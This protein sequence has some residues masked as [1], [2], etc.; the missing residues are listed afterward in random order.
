MALIKTPIGYIERI[1]FQKVEDLFYIKCQ[2]LGG[3]GYHRYVWQFGI[4]CFW[5][6]IGNFVGC[7]KLGNWLRTK[8]RREQVPAGQSGQLC[9]GFLLNEGNSSQLFAG[10]LFKRLRGGLMSE[11][12]KTPLGYLEMVGLAKSEQD[13][14]LCVLD[15]GAE[16]RYFKSGV[17]V[18]DDFPPIIKKLEKICLVVGGVLLIPLVYMAYSCFSINSI[19][20][21]PVAK[22]ANFGSAQEE[23]LRSLMGVLDGPLGRIMAVGQF[24]VGGYSLSI[25]RIEA[26]VMSFVGASLIYNAGNIANG[27]LGVPVASKASSSSSIAFSMADPLLPIVGILFLVCLVIFILS[28]KTLMKWEKEYSAL[29]SVSVNEW[30]E[31]QGDLDFFSMQEVKDVPVSVSAK[32]ASIQWISKANEVGADIAQQAFKVANKRKLHG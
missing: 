20:A 32:F 15:D 26:A 4:G 18:E 27:L 6:L 12:I 16:K 2:D 29:R 9:P 22:A 31:G 28:V 25:Q 13:I 24:L 14:Y 17:V 10:W 1:K 7:F 19:P 21:A 3:G 8:K 11:F 5:W 23:V 30:V